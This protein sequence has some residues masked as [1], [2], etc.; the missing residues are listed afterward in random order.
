MYAILN[1][2]QKLELPP[3]PPMS[4]LGTEKRFPMKEDGRKRR[5]T[6]AIWLGVDCNDMVFPKLDE[7]SRVN[8]RVVGREE[9]YESKAFEK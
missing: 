6:V 5:M 1:K 3:L 8:C 4:G 9:L 7:Q 2:G